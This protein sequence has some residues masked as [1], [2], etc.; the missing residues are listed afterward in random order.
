MIFFK[1]H[2]VLIFLQLNFWNAKVYPI[3][4]ESFYFLKTEYVRW[5]A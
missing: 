3:E 5:N 4:K 2:T 1:Y